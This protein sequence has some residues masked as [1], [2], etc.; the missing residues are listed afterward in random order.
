MESASLIVLVLGSSVRYNL[1]FSYDDGIS[2]GEF[3]NAPSSL[4]DLIRKVYT[5]MNNESPKHWN[6]L[7][8]NLNAEGNLILNSNRIRINKTNLNEIVVFNDTA[9]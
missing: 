5:E 9:H 8:F 2:G 1:K 4:S 3:L 6:K 7:L